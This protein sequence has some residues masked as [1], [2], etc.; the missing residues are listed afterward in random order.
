MNSYSSKI[1]FGF[2]LLAASVVMVPKPARAVT[3]SSVLYTLQIP[4]LK[5]VAPVISVGLTSDGRM[6]VPNNYKQ[7]GLLNNAPRPGE[8]GSAVLAAHVDN[9]GKIAGVFKQIKTLRIGDD[10]YT[11]D[12]A[13]KVLHFKVV[14]MKV[15]DKNSTNTE[16]VF[17]MKDRSRL[18]LVTC[19][20]LY[21]PKENTYDRRL[22]VFTELV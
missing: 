2:F 11:T 16:N 9:G 5:V 7:I 22:V 12:T 17:N 4:K 20:G 1:V 3:S 14:A 6:D 10:I 18:N 21:L 8:K 19:F 13:G 15:Y